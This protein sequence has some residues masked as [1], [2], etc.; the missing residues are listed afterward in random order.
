MAFNKGSLRHQVCL[1]KGDP[2]KALAAI[3]PATT[4]V[5]LLPRP[6]ETGTWV[7]EVIL[8]PVAG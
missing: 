7:S 3:R 4:A 2:A 8:M 6:R 1:A 5:E